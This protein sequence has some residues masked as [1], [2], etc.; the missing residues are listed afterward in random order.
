MKDNLFLNLEAHQDNLKKDKENLLYFNKILHKRKGFESL[1]S[2]NNQVKRIELNKYTYFKDIKLSD[3][4]FLRTYFDDNNRE[5]KL[6]CNKI[7]RFLEYRL[8]TIQE[9][10]NKNYTKKKDQV[11]FVQNIITLLLECYE[12]K[13]DERF[14]SIAL[15]LL[16][17]SSLAKYGLF[18]NKTS[19]QYS[20]NVLAAHNLIKN[21]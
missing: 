8:S 10:L 7:H 21:L 11:I 19:V 17:I 18:N 13:G 2:K 15:K 9:R 3:I 4:L 16:R 14:L 1:I 5:H 6:W 12:R 20:Y